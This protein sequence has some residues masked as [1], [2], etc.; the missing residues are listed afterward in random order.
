MAIITTDDPD[1]DD[2]AEVIADIATCF[3]PGSCPHVG[4]VDRREA[5]RY[6]LEQM[7]PGD[8][9][10]LCGKGPGGLPAGAMGRRSP[11][12]KRRRSAP[13]PRE[14]LESRPQAL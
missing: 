10:L 5:V 9:L 14:L 3:G 6:A 2:P 7:R 8:M 1:R 13:A 4:I 12:T 11:T